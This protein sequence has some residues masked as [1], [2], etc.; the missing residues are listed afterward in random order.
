VSLTALLCL[1]ELSL[2]RF[3]TARLSARVE[4]TAHHTGLK[5]TPL[6][7]LKLKPWSC[8]TQLD[9]LLFGSAL[10]ANLLL[11]FIDEAIAVIIQKITLYLAPRLRQP[12]LTAQLSSQTDKG[13]HRADPPLQAT[14]AGLALLGIC[15]IDA[16][17]A[18]I[19]LS[20][21]D[22]LLREAGVWLLI[23]E[24]CEIF[25]NAREILG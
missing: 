18:V 1:P 13:T 15:L 17:V 2:E 16:T 20:I 19:V 21:A 7:N 23:L 12:S 4:P 3:N 24:S 11:R 10:R 5:A 25:R 9:H 22:L 14:P 8:T 6:S